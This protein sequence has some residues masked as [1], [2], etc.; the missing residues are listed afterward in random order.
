MP[1]H[2]SVSSKTFVCRN[3]DPA[4][5]GS[6]TMADGVEPGEEDGLPNRDLEIFRSAVDRVNQ[7]RLS[8]EKIQQKNQAAIDGAAVKLSLFTSNQPDFRLPD[9]SL[10]LLRFD[11]L[12]A[13]SSPQ[14]PLFY[15]DLLFPKFKRQISEIVSVLARRESQL[16]N[17]IA[18]FGRLSEIIRSQ[19]R[20]MLRSIQFALPPPDPR[21]SDVISAMD[22][23]PAAAERLALRNDWHPNQLQR[24][25]IRIKSRVDRISPAEIHR[26]A[27]VQGVLW[28]LGG[29]KEA[30]VPISIGPQSMWLYDD[31][32]NVT[33]IA[34][35]QQLPMDYFWIWLDQE[36]ARAAGLWLV[37]LPYAPSVVLEVPPDG[38]SDWKFA[39][40]T[41]QSSEERVLPLHRGRPF[42][43]GVFEDGEAL[44]REVRLAVTQVESRDD[45]IT[46]ERIAEVMSQRGFMEGGDP[47]RQL[48]Q[49]VREFGFCDWK[50]LL[51]SL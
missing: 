47:N 43:S 50:D 40:F 23:D 24:E 25:C 38:S 49:W 13:S 3:I 9:E 19:T 8:V 26:M 33:T 34:P 32:L 45:R 37:G 46:E 6:I 39:I 20:E 22:G 35:F 36:V 10:K 15:Q 44:L 42:G 48:R 5:K 18:D 30:E 28:V 51:K 17:V 31:Q 1:R 21:L 11:S 16:K 27:L 7:V 4:A 2:L 41:S 14:S 12:F 29:E